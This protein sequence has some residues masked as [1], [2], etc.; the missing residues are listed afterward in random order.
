MLKR[1]EKTLSNERI[2]WRWAAT[3][4]AAATLVA[5]GGD[6]LPSNHLPRGFTD[7][8]VTAYPATAVSTGSTAATQDLL[9]GGIGKTGLGAAAAPIYADPANPTAAELRRNA[10]YSNYR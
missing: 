3:A 4:V 9:T 6:I 10:L 7:L 5:C 1:D 2:S 8:G